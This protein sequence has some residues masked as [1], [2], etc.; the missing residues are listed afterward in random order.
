[1]YQ[2]NKS[3]V[4]HRLRDGLF[5]HILLQKNDVPDTR[6]SITWVEIEPGAAQKPHTHDPEQAYIIVQGRGNMTVAAESCLVARGDIVHIPANAEHWI[7]NIGERDLIYVSASTP[8]LNF[9]TLYDSGSLK[10]RKD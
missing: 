3:E 7:E 2:R 5:S 6:L 10:P 8:A 1:M 9:E 4:P